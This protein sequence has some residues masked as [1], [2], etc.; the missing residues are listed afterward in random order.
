MNNLTLNI[1]KAFGIRKAHNPYRLTHIVGSDYTYQKPHLE[2]TS[3]RKALANAIKHIREGAE[4]SRHAT[5]IEYPRTRAGFGGHGILHLHP[6][7]GNVT[8]R[9]QQHGQTDNDLFSQTY[10]KLWDT[11]AAKHGKTFSAEDLKNA[12]MYPFTGR[13]DWAKTNLPDSWKDLDTTFK[14]QAIAVRDE[15]AFAR[16]NDFVKGHNTIAGRS[17]PANKIEV[18]YPR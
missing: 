15:S 6:K 9:H 17:N 5:M 2:T 8:L 4:D 10:S 11:H 3:K 13:R 16:M 18:Q 14:R 1:Y 12:A 7:T